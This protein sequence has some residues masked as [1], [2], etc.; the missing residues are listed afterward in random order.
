MLGAVRIVTF[1]VHHGTVAKAGPVD[2]ERL[3][4]V[5]AAFDA[6]VIGLQEV[7][8]GTYRTG[9]ADLAAV[10]ARGCGM[11]HAFGAARRFPGG[12][13]GNAL[14]VRGELRS[15]SVRALPRFPAWRLLQ[16]RRAVLEA[17]VEVADGALA[18]AVTHLAVPQG[19]NGP[20]LDHLLAGL[21][22]RNG[23]MA[24]IGDLNRRPAGV[25]A[26]ARAAGLTM[27]PHGPT[28]P[29]PHPV[30]PIDHVL[31]GG[32]LRATGVEVRETDMSDHAALLVDVAVDGGGSRSPEGDPGAIDGPGR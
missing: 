7:D 9:R 20:Q 22:G 28:N 23:P 10:V 26:P 27:V 5:C 11:D 13:Y 12:W 4:A 14:L 17:E 31:L 21:A 29:V 16:E 8:L 3:G 19:V 25:E 32:G 15:W 24:V 6:D 1:N 18:V 30:R 2:P